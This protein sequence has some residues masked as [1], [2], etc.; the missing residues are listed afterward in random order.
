[1]PTSG[2]AMPGRSAARSGLLRRARQLAVHHGQLALRQRDADAH[3]V[4]VI[5]DRPQQVGLGGPQVIGPGPGAYDQVDRAFTQFRR[6]YARRRILEY[7]FVLL[8]QL[9][10]LGHRRADVVLEADPYGEVEAAGSPAVVVED[11]IAAHLAVWHDR[12]AT[13]RQHQHGVHQ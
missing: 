9:P 11:R 8:E 13:V 10:D 3:L 7:A 2:A 5:L 6:P 4:E 12:L 1:M